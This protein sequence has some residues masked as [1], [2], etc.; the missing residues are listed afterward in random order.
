MNLLH[1]KGT[2][3]QASRAFA[4]IKEYGIATDQDSFKGTTEFESFHRWMCEYEQR[5]AGLKALDPSQVS[6][7]VRTAMMEDKIPLPTHLIFAGFEEIIPQLKRLLRL[8]DDCKIPVQFWP[9]QNAKA[10][11]GSDMEVRQYENPTEEA[12]QCARWVRQIFNA[13]TEPAQAGTVGIVVPDIAEYRDVLR[14]ELTAELTPKAIF[15]WEEVE[16]RFNFSEGTPLALEPCI[17]TALLLISIKGDAV[18]FPVISTILKTPFLSGGHSEF[19]ARQS[20]DL[21]LRSR[22]SVSV[23][24][25]SLKKL[26]G[27]APRLV[28]LIDSLQ[29]QQESRKLPS[30]W[31]HDFSYLLKHNGWPKGDG[32]L[33]PLQI[34]VLEA[35]KECL[36]DFSSLDN[37]L[38]E[39]SRSR[40]VDTLGRITHDKQFNA[41]IGEHPIQ[42]VSLP[43]A[44]GMQFDH[45]W[46]VGCH[47]ESMPA[48]PSPNPFIPPHIQRKHDLPHSTAQ[49]ELQYAEK[50]LNQLRALS[51]STV[52][53][54]PERSQKTDLRMS[55]LLKS[56]DYSSSSLVTNHSHRCKDQLLTGLS[57]EALED[58]VIIPIPRGEQYSGG[59]QILKNQ[60]DCP[61][62]AFAKHRL[63]AMEFKNPEIDH[64]STERGNIVHKTLHI[65]WSDVK[66][67]I[68]LHKLKADNQLA[69]KIR[70]SINKAINALKLQICDQKQFTELEIKRLELLLLGWLE[71]ELKRPEFTVVAM[72]SNDQIQIGALDI[73]VR[74]DRMD[75]VA[76]GKTIL[77]D[78]KTGKFS[79]KNWFEDRLQ[80]IQLPLYAIKI[81]PSAVGFAEVNKGSKGNGFKYLAQDNTVLPG[82]KPID[83]GEI[84]KDWDSLLGR[85][86]TQLTAL[87]DEFMAGQMEVNPYNINE[88][89]KYCGLQTLCR[90][91]E[92]KP[93]FDEES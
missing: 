61:F 11:A 78:Y 59:Y 87:A 40:A 84:C 93:G 90:I 44:Y 42:V 82:F 68:S 49:R 30:S 86:K 23:H 54:F 56:C 13:G 27:N 65:F 72:E 6:D 14:R 77:I 39:I 75:Q 88:T 9:E 83:F 2:A 58:P 20:V 45:L 1:L 4:L 48:L 17:N 46:I 63:H 50:M 66:T 85:W 29:N 64:D 62:R 22:N 89:C 53:S 3:S 10:F 80:E 5:L 43:E 15:P 8:F 81:N 52:I 74:I 7:F 73:N 18:P 51:S 71:K 33:S 60:S 55:P 79:T 91:E 12:V 92:R 67:W 24:L 16:P 35:W 47:A 32:T 25:G 69:I 21:E 36:D 28:F 70:E 57:H 37:I 76:N 31:A 41:D 26:L 34:Q 19:D 38:G